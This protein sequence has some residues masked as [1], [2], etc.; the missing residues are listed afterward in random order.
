MRTRRRFSGEFKTKVALEAIQGRQTV[1]FSENLTDD[2]QLRQLG[3]G[4]VK[5]NMR[6]VLLCCGFLLPCSSGFTSELYY[7]NE[8]IAVF[9]GQF[10]TG[11]MG[12]SW[13]WL[14]PN[15]EKNYVVAASYSRHFSDLWFGWLLD[16][17]IG[18]AG[19]FGDGSSAEGW[20]GP[21]LRHRG[22]SVG[23][24]FT[25]SA[26]ITIGLSVVSNPIGIERP[27][28][29]LD[30]G[31]TILLAYLGPEASLFFHSL[32]HLEFFYRL[33]HRSGAFGKLGKMWEGANAN[34]IGVRYWLPKDFLRSGRL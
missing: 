27:R 11:N 5:L 32:P 6:A 19:R 15:Y 30:G 12:E 20:L 16:G 3:V 2:S 10:T 29:L 21:R 26:S 24:V 28:Q 25:L 7:R 33:H 1:A 34:V 31:N 14:G 18:V 4:G 23:D 17:E 9:G 8:S 22:I 13:V